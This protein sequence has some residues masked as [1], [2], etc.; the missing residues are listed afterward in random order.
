M[1]VWTVYG[2][3]NDGNEDNGQILIGKA[4][5][6]PLWAKKYKSYKQDW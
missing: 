1:K 4:H 6:S 2:A 5:L 3:N